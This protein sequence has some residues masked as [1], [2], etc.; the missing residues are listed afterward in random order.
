MQGP[1][2]ELL[3]GT[4]EL[5]ETEELE[6]TELED[7]TEL[8]DTLLEDTLEEDWLEDDTTELLD[9][10]SGKPSQRTSSISKVPASPVWPVICQLKAFALARASATLTVTSVHVG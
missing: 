8:D 10:S 3:D 6:L 2:I 1:P 5:D 7:E 9:A 4:T